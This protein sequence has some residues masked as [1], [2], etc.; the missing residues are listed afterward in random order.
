MYFAENLKTIRKFRNI[1][2]AQLADKAKVSSSSIINYENKRRK[3]PSMKVVK[4]LAE[5]LEIPPEYLGDEEIII[6]NGQ[7]LRENYML[8]AKLQNSNELHH[9]KGIQEREE[10]ISIYDKLNQ[11][12]Q[13]RL[14]DLAHDLSELPRYK[15]ESI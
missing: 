11:E 6:S 13:K 3:D 10:L 7:I 1:T 2:Q 8:T 5:A 14:V 12:G 4:K 15:K 9:G